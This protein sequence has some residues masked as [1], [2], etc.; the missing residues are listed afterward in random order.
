MPTFFKL[1]NIVQLLLTV[2][3]GTAATLGLQ[4]RGGSGGGHGGGGHGSSGHASGHA[5]TGGHA[6]RGNHAASSAHA[7]GV[8]IPSAAGVA[9]APTKGASTLAGAAV[10]QMSIGNHCPVSGTALGTRCHPHSVFFCHGYA[11]P[12]IWWWYDSDYY[13]YEQSY[14]DLGRRL[15][16]DLREQRLTWDQLLDAIQE[17]ILNAPAGAR[18]DFRRGFLWGYGKGGVSVFIKAMEQARAA[19]ATKPAVEGEGK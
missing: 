18:N 16:Q 10:T 11:Q 3:I 19:A 17:E 1:R 8:A 13:T 4:A 9:M 7:S 2:F 6:S 15:A 12:L 14:E 5:S